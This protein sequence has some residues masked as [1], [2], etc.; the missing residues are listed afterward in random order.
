MY[1]V[2]VGGSEMDNYIYDKDKADFI[3]ESWRKLGYDDVIVESIEKEG[4]S[5]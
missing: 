2:W 1:A 4:E 5:K 3:A